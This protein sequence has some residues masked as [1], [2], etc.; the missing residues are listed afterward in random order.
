VATQSGRSSQR[1]A[2]RR[3]AAVGDHVWQAKSRSP[4]RRRIRPIA[5]KGT[6]KDL[7]RPT[8]A[9]RHVAAL[10]RS[11]QSTYLAPRRPQN[12]FS[13][14]SQA[15]RSA[16]LDSVYPV[17]TLSQG[18]TMPI[19]RRDW[20]R[21]PAQISFVLRHRLRSWCRPPRPRARYSSRCADA[22]LLDC[23]GL[24]RQ[25]CVLASKGNSP[26]TNVVEVYQTQ[27]PVLCR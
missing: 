19:T 18:S 23:T 5:G 9:G 25:R 10:L 14:F 22:G 17:S 7:R 4:L 15:C 6:C 2:A 1:D 12:F 24:A 8:Q 3:R 21:L 16:A 13:N 27:S 20:P 26:P 11:T